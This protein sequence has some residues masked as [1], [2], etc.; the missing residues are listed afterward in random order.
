[1]GPGLRRMSVAWDETPAMRTVR[2]WLNACLPENGNRLPYLQRAQML[3]AERGASP[4][5]IGPA[6]V[7]WGNTDADYAGAVSFERAEEEGEART[8]GYASLS[9][10]EIGDRLYEAW[11]VANQEGKGPAKHYP[12]RR[13]SLTGMRGKI[14]LTPDGGGGWHAATGGALN[15]W[16]AKREDSP[17]LRGEAGIESICQDVMALVGIPA[18]RTAS[19][20][21]AGQQCVLSERSDRY[22]DTGH[23]EVMARH[24]EEFCQAA[25]WPGESKYDGGSNR[26]P[27]WEHAYRL[28]AKHAVD[29]ATEQGRLTRILAASWLIGHTDLHRRNLGFCHTRL[30]EPMGVRLAPVYDVSSGIGTHLDQALAI[31]IAR[32]Q[33]FSRLG[34]VQWMQHARECEQDT[35]ETLA[36]VGE[37]TRLLPDAITSARERAKTRDENRWQGTVD[38]RI[39]AMLDYTAARAKVFE[40]AIGR[41]RR[42]GARGLE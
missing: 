11:R 42:K 27:R 21:F 41:M 3:R 10:R 37:M 36:I 1:M 5:A 35:E 13:T 6:D 18:A 9:E 30:H 4:E 20:V 8:K 14:G 15:T 40:E 39:E 24:Q 17:R 31:G 2:T 22:R 33:S 29:P 32:Q 28:L 26:E 19:R 16:V 23:G 25:G 12:E 34:P 7:L 38:R